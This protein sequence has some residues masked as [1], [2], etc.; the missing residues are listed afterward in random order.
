MIG[1]IEMQNPTTVIAENNEHKKDFERSCW[2]GEKIER[3]EF[4]GVIL[5]KCSPAL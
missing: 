3:D 4:P 5:Q 1:Y 2:N